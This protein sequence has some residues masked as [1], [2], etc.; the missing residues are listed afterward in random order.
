MIYVL[1][2]LFKSRNKERLRDVILITG[3]LFRREFHKCQSCMFRE[4]SEKTVM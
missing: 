1:T 2:G 4:I 3:E